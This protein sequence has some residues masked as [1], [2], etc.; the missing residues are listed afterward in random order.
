MA[1]SD[2]QREILDFAYEHGE[3]TKK[4]AIV[5]IGGSYY[6]NSDKHVGDILSRLVKAGNLIRIKPGLFKIGTGKPQK[7]QTPAPNQQSL[8]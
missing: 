4:E 8:F 7:K 2:K 1:L 5:L 3:I 6:C